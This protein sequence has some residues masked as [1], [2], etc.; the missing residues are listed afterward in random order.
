MTCLLLMKFYLI[1][2]FNNKEWDRK[3]LKKDEDVVDKYYKIGR[4]HV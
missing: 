3:Q 1:L 2:G 4:A